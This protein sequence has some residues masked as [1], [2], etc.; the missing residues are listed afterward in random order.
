MESNDDYYNILGI[1]KSANETDIKKAYRKLAVKFH[2]DK[3][4]GNTE[5]EEKF[6]KINEAY[7]VLS[8]KEKKEKYDRFGVEGLNSGQNMNNVN[9]NEI[10]NMFFG[11]N[12]PFNININNMGGHTR[13]FRSGNGMSFQSFNSHRSMHQKPLDGVIKSGTIVLIKNLQNASNFNNCSGIIKSYNDMKK[14]YI[15]AV[16]NKSIYIQRNNFVQLL[17]VQIYN[18]RSDPTLNGRKTKII[19]ILN[20]RY[21]IDIDNKRYSLSI[22]NLIV[23]TGSCVEIINLESKKE[24]N[25]KYGTVID[26]DSSC[27]RYLIKINKAL[28]VKIKMNNISI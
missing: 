7:S 2:P 13:I 16:N 20:D 11:G 28:I 18:L 22:N 12:D 25:G 21:V 8:D 4:P 10:F 14:K 3:N 19:D 6:K 5:A 27:D 1:N 26:F 24:L 23:N 9:P 17:E 15:V